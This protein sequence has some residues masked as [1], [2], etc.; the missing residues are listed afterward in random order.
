MSAT[1]QPADAGTLIERADARAWIDR[2]IL[3]ATERGEVVDGALPDYLDELLALADADLRTKMER[4]GLAIIHRQQDADAIDAEIKR[5]QARKTATLNA[6]ERIK[7]YAQVCLE[8][9]GETKVATPLVTVALQQNPPSVKGDPDQET[10]RMWWE[11]S[12]PGARYV[13]ESYALDRRAVLD[14]WKAGAALPEGLTVE[15]T[16]SLRVR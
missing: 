8:I 14:A 11:N 7:R 12:V 13:P 6:V 3:L 16:T 15:R 5:L 9:A 2:E 10:L 4:T 1:L